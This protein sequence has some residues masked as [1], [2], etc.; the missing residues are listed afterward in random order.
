ML[1]SR[2]RECVEISKVKCTE[3]INQSQND[4]LIKDSVLE[5]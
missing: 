3:S 4:N 5:I 2:E 1:K